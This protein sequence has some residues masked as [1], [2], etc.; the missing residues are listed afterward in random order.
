MGERGGGREGGERR[1]KLGS[2]GD[3]RGVGSRE[4]G[5][6]KTRG[7]KRGE[8]GTGWVGREGE[9]GREGRERRLRHN[10]GEWL[11]LDDFI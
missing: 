11:H 10:N 4:A 5:E 7:E 3:E 1:M 6:R 8:D 9:G 2:R